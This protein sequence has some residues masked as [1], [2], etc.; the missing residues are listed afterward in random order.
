MAVAAGMAIVTKAAVQN[1]LCS[2]SV[3]QTLVTLLKKFELPVTSRYTTHD[4][5]QSALSDKKRLGSS[6]NLIVPREIGN[7]EIIPVR[8]SELQSFIEAGL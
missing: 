6:V 8:I 3:Y 2:E 5:Y 7:C 1:G 4:L